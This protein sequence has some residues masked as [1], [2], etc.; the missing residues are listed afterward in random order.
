MKFRRPSGAAVR[1]RGLTPV[2][3]AGNRFGVAGVCLALLG[4]LCASVSDLE[5]AGWAFAPMAMVLGGT[6][7][8]LWLRDEATNRTDA[9][10]GAGLGYVVLMVLLFKLAVAYP[11]TVLPVS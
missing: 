1:D 8:V 4:L 2:Q 9:M 10:I 3:R 11:L 7:L 5:P 6:G